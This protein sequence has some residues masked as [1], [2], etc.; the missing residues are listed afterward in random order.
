MLHVEETRGVE[1][2]GVVIWDGVLGISPAE[3]TGCIP[4]GGE[5]RFDWA[6]LWKSL[7]I[8]LMYPSIE[9]SQVRRM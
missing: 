5:F 7:R 1:A 9:S 2:G 8:A 6:G 4:V 3:G